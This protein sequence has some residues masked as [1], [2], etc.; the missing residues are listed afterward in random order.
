MIELNNKSTVSALKEGYNIIYSNSKGTIKESAIFYK[1]VTRIISLLSDSKLLD[2]GCGGGYFLREVSNL[3]ITINSFGV[4]IS[5]VALK[6]ATK[7]SPSSVFITSLAERLPFKN[8]SFDYITCLGCLE[9]FNNPAKG[10][11]EFVRVVK[12]N[13]KVLIL[14]PNAYDLMIILRVLLT[15]D[16]FGN[17]AG[18]GQPI[19]RHATKN[20]WI[21]LINSNGL[22]VN[23]I[24][25]YNIFPHKELKNSNRLLYKSLYRFIPLNLSYCFLF[26]CSLNND[27]VL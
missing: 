20:Q 17:S 24:I 12:P 16:M 3:N 6:L 1:W 23:K 9:H 21:R 2:V 15:G 18:E 7:E 11:S 10:V 27:T 8:N 4:D 14:V 13:G 26:V 19:E 5:E 22:K 25:K